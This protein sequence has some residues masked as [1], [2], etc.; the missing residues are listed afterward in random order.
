MKFI[1]GK[2]IEMTQVYQGDVAVPVTR[3]KLLP[4][5]VM[6]VKTNSTDGY[7]AVVIGCGER[8]IKNIAK[9]QQGAMKGL[10]NF[11]YIKEFRALNNADAVEQSKLSRGNQ[12]LIESFE[13][14]DLTSVV[15][16]SK[17]RG[18]QGVV[19]RHRFHGHNTTHGT[20]D[21]VRMPGSIGAGEPQHVFKGMRMG[22]H[23]GDQGVTVKNLDIVQIDL[24]AEEMMIKGALPGSRNSLLYITAPGE[25]KYSET[26]VEAPKKAEPAVA[27]E[28]V[29]K[30]EEAV[31]VETPVVEPAVAEAMADK[32]A[33]VETPEVKVE[34]PEVKVEET[35]E[36]AP[37]ET[38]SEKEAK[39][40]AKSAVIAESVDA[41]VEKFNELPADVQAK[42]SSQEAQAVI[43][44]LEE[45]FKVDLVPVVMK[46]AINELKAEELETY[47]VASLKIEAAVA[48]EIAVA[49]KEQILK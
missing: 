26:K 3:V 33:E 32:E 9:P 30:A 23:M 31:V 34:T 12:I 13:I 42:Y 48:A 43:S 25:L 40:E 17:G 24:E 1:V 44:K 18:F 35:K 8:R 28:A 20:K 45:Q 22:G 16:V 11:R 41:Q 19:K 37:A 39:A 36:A 6:Q 15:G 10:G 27:V 7:N 38:T 14:G 5:V 2:K 47:L 21:Q 29:E 46:L 49:I 4:G